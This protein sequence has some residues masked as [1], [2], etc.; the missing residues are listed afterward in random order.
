MLH[1]DENVDDVFAAELAALLELVLVNDV[2]KNSVKLA[3]RPPQL[4]CAPAEDIQ[5]FL[6]GK[7]SASVKPPAIAMADA[8]RPS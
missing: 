3:A 8:M 6:D 4:V 2:V 1:P 5:Q 7:R